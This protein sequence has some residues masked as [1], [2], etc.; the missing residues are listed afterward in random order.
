M[1]IDIC[2]KRVYTVSQQQYLGNLNF[3]FS[4][5]CSSNS[6]F[7]KKHIEESS[8][9]LSDI[10]STFTGFIGC[11]AKITLNRASCRQI[12]VL[13]GENVGKF[14][15]SG[16]F[17]YDFIPENIKGGTKDMKKLARKNKIIIRKTGKNL[18]AALD[19]RGYIIEQS[20]YG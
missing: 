9:K 20:L 1:N 5:C 8:K 3:E 14:K 2:E 13:K 17:Y 19:P 15:I 11:S 18:I 12:E 4:H 16:N 10:C 7:L 6:L